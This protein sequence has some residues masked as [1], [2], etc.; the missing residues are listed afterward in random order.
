MAKT[1]QTTTTV[2]EAIRPS[3]NNDDDDDDDERKK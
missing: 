3:P 2:G 1:A